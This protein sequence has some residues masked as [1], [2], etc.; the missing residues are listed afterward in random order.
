MLEGESGLELLFIKLAPVLAILT[1]YSFYKNSLYHSQRFTHRYREILSV[2]K[3]NTFAS[4][5]FILFLYF[6]GFERVSRL[7]LLIYFVLSTLSLIIVRM[8]I[9]N[10]LRSLRRKGKNLRHV[11]L[12]GNGAPLKNYV[13]NTRVFKDSGINFLG[14]LDSSGLAEELEMKPLVG[15]YKDL[16]EQLKPDAV[17][18]SYN[19]INSHKIESFI[20]ENHNDIIPIQILPDLSYSLIGHHIEDFG[21]IPL[22]TVNQPSFNSMELF[23]KRGLDIFGSLIGLIILSP[24]FALFSLLIKF[25]SKGPIFY[26]QERLGLDGNNFKM[27]KFRTMKAATEQEDETEWSNKENPRKTKLGDFM[28]KTSIDEFPQL[29]NVFLGDMSLVGPRPERPFFVSKF[30]EEIP[31][32]ML[33]HKM[34]A[35]ITGWAQVNGWRGDTSLHK[36]IDCDIYYIKH[37]SFWFDAKILF[38]TIFKGFVNKNAY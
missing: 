33:R 22:L 15:N 20:Q 4:V 18:I 32:Y 9:R 34:K 37:W 7:A 30:R 21:G 12:I 13:E 11:I 26:G 3:A 5:A 8:S 6:F 17:V 29:L 1:H 16:K 14:W 38:L 28:R 2:V 25:S 27:W 36:R 35:G 31:G 10:F 23:L 19:G 24:F